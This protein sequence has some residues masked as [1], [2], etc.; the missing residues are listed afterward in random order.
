ML[1]FKCPCGCIFTLKDTNDGYRKNVHCQSCGKTTA[2][3]PPIQKDDLDASL[4]QSGMSMQI[5]P[6]NAK[7]TVTFDT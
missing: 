2:F 3:S 4:A 1:L 6:D 5:I 7:I